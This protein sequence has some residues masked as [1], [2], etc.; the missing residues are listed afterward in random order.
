MRQQDPE[1]RRRRP[2]PEPHGRLKLEK[3]EDELVA[4]TPGPPGGKERKSGEE[5]G[6]DF[7][8]IC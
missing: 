6:G 4:I 7:V 8:V 5:E 1:P 3:F 2:V